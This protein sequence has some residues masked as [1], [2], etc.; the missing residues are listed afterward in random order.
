MVA[1]LEIEKKTLAHMDIMEITIRVKGNMFDFISAAIHLP[2][3]STSTICVHNMT[4][5][6]LYAKEFLNTLV[7][8]LN[9]AS[10]QKKK[11]F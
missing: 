1:F 2:S 11:I 8:L 6:Y 7:R 3:P 10:H 9:W 4:Q 5:N